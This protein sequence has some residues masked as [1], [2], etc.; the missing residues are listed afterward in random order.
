MEFANFNSHDQPFQHSCKYLEILKVKIGAIF[1][2]L[3][4]V[5]VERQMG[6]AGISPYPLPPVEKRKMEGMSD[7]ERL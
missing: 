2:I 1:P 5:I 3:D 6:T 7:I 4:K